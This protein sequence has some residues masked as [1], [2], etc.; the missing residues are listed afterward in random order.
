[1]YFM[2]YNYFKYLKLYL[3][4]ANM[5]KVIILDS[6][7]SKT[8]WPQ[9]WID[10]FCPESNIPGNHQTNSNAI[11]DSLEC[12]LNL[13]LFKPIMTPD[14]YECQQILI[15]I[16]IDEPC[17]MQFPSRLFNHWKPSNSLNERY[18]LKDVRELH[19]IKLNLSKFGDS[20][21]DIST[22]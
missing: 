6:S 7:T 10:E 21:Q 13:S 2:S 20:N 22:L 14:A 12:N 16:S 11:N 9:P 3:Y 15:G 18:F 4:F 8:T 19:S 17:H 5:K 1:M